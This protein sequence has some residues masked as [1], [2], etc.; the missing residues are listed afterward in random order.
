VTFALQFSGFVAIGDKIDSRLRERE[1]SEK[2]EH[3]PSEQASVTG[4]YVLL[5]AEGSPTTVRVAAFQG[6][7]CPVAPQGWMWQLDP[8]AA[9]PSD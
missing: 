9:L 2:T 5:N 7:A 1:V 6:T 3:K 4:M 8:E